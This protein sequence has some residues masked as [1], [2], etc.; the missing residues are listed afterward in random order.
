[1]EVFDDGPICV[2][3]GFCGNQVTNVWKMAAKTGDS[4]I[5]AQAMAMIERCP[6]GAITYQVDGEPIEQICPRRSQ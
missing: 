2:H 3:A 4:Q 1:M 6:S 5:S